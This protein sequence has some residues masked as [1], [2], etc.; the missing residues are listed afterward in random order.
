[1]KCQWETP[2]GA[3]PPNGE[4]RYTQN[5][6]SC[7]GGQSCEPNGDAMAG[8]QWRG[9]ALGNPRQWGKCTAIA[10]RMPTTGRNQQRRY[11]GTIAGLSRHGGQRR[12]IHGLFYTIYIA[13][14]RHHPS[15]PKP[16]K[17][18]QRKPW[19][20]IFI[21]GVAILSPVVYIIN[22]WSRWANAHERT[23]AGTLKESKNNE[24]SC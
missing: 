7:N 11:D 19:Q 10:I 9:L 4:H 6:L 16:C 1:M 15:E 24:I 2:Q 8:M 14:K 21:L 23:Q 17:E 5:G 22:Q 13:P 18:S 20:I 12:A 3:T